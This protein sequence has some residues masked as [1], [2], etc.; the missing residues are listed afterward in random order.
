MFNNRSLCARNEKNNKNINKP[1]CD[2]VE[3]EPAAIIFGICKN[4]TL[5]DVGQKLKSEWG[6]TGVR[7]IF[8]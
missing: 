7:I 5:L 8:F 4:E 6:Q 1:A 2:G 3:V